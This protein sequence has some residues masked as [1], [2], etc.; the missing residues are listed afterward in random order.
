MKTLNNAPSCPDEIFPRSEPETLS[1]KIEKMVD[2][3]PMPHVTLTEIVEKI[4]AEGL[5]V[6]SVVLSVVFLVPVSIPGVSTVFGVAIL[7]VGVSRLRSRELRVPARIAARRLP[8]ERLQVALRKSLGCFRK[9]EKISKPQRMRR[10]AS[11]ES[12][13]IFN[14][15]CFILSAILLMMPF[16]FVPFSNTLPAVALICLALGMMQQDGLTI[17][18]GHLCNAFTLVYFG[19]L[20]AGGGWS[21]SRLGGLM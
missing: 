20:I 4:G 11:T 5:L 2:E 21:L 19:F 10:L 13:L 16:G 15:L 7:L 9:I 1:G 14:N 8:S 12:A 3:L 18:W 17:L 6:L